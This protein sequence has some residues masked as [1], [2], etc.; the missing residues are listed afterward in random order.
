MYAAVEK[1]KTTLVL[2]ILP[3]EFQ[4]LE[5]IAL[6]EFDI[7]RPINAGRVWNPRFAVKEQKKF[8]TI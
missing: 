2:R 8:Q 3:A 5:Y 7:S 4:Q 1:L 6:S